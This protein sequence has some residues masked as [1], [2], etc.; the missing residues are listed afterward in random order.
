MFGGLFRGGL[1]SFWKFFRL[2]EI[3]LNL[4][5]RT[6]SLVAMNLTYRY[7]TARQVYFSC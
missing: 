5:S 2:F 7:V 1:I 3:F 6:D 4:N